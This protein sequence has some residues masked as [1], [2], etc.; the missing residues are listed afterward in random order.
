MIIGGYDLESTGLNEP[1]HRII[2]VCVIA[3]DYDPA[4]HAF[5]E[6]DCWT[7]RIN[8]QRSIDPKAR[9]VHGISES[10]LVGKPTFDLVAPT[11]TQKLD[12]LDVG[13]GHNLID[14]DAPFTIRELERVGAQ[15]PD[16][17]PF[18]TMLEGRWATAFG[19]APNLQELCWASGE[20]YDPALAHAAE[21][22]VRRMMSCFFYGLRRQVFKLSTN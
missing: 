22:D 5:E 13:V 11:L 10:D 14:F 15:L 16:F 19:K 20:H 8:P 3:Y 4:T 12:R 21:Y 1:Q 18:D 9:E 2:E 6:I 7:Q 17:E